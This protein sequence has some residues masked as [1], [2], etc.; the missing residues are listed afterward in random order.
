MSKRLLFLKRSPAVDLDGFRAELS[1]GVGAG[2]MIHLT[3]SSGYRAH[4]PIYDAVIETSDVG[5]AVP[6]DLVDDAGSG[7]L[8]VEEVVIVDGAAPPDGVTVFY[9]LNRLPGMERSEF[10]HYWRGHH[11]PIAS[12]VPGVRRYVQNHVVGDEGVYD[13]VAQTSFDALDAMRTSAGSAELALT[14]A[15]EPNFM[16]SGRLP[17]VICTSIH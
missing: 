10:Q 4:E 7:S 1:Q 14:R 16:V 15:D 8:D 6:N 2:D 17:F 9:F 5:R 3:H 12:R 13:G 11:G